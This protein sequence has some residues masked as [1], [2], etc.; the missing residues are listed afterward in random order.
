MVSRRL[1]LGA[2]IFCLLVGV[3]GLGLYV[4]QRIGQCGYVPLL[5]AEL[6]PNADLATP[7]AVPRMPQGWSAAAA[8]VEL[9]AFAVDG[10][11]RSLQLMGIANYVQT[12]PI[13]VTG[14]QVYCF[15][16][17]AL[18]D[19]VQ[20]SPTR[21]QLTFHWLA[22]DGTALG[23]AAGPW[24]PVALWQPEAPPERWSTIS[25]AARAPQD[26]VTLLV[27]IHPASDDRVYLDA[28]HVRRGGG[29]LLAG[30]ATLAAPVADASAAEPAAPLLAPWPY[31]QRAA[32]AFTFDWETTMGGLIHS[33]SVGDPNF[34]AD[35]VLR[36]LRMREG[37][38]NTLAIFRPYDL[39]ATYYATG[40]NFLT[41]NTARERF[42]GDPIYEWANPANGWLSE[43][44]QTTPWFADDPYGT[45]RSH[46]AWYFGDLIPLLQ[47]AGQDIQ[48]HTFSH[49]H[50]GLVASQEW[51]ADLQAWNRVA[52]AQN[53]PSA[54]SLAFPWS[55]SAGMSDASWNVLDAAG[56]RSVT[57]LSDQ[58]Q[59]NLFPRDEAGLVVAP[60][61]RP[62]PGHPRILA[63]PDFYLTP[64]SADLAIR[65]I[66]HTLASG[67]MIDLWAHTEEVTTPAQ[68]AAWQRVVAYAVDQPDLWVAPLTEIADWQ[69]ALAQVAVSAGQ[70]AD[71]GGLMFRV[72]NDSPRDLGGLTLRMPFVVEQVT[73]NGDRPSPSY[74]ALGSQLLTLDL[75]A[76][77]SLE[78]VAWP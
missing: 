62:L 3:F 20:R 46:P 6:L 12:P 48:S 69:Q 75:A 41:G 14:G 22:A 64:A 1:L 7:G 67:G 21:L 63:C 40:Y 68:I 29:G 13:D 71:A 52:A 39:R 38:T 58:A 56:I 35:P 11:G 66:D 57:R 16:G 59:Y 25:A 44:W 37:I 78:V 5:A 74:P 27:R 61:C 60:H 65:Q 54:R 36:G 42:M 26:A 24:Q 76:G 2:T 23:V 45:Y 15:R 10:D 17:L 31:G 30:E 49:F 8:G 70:P 77:Q 18:T 19:S 43:R 32:L 47:A 73:L 50:G 53:V 4:Q 9:G 72:A 55:S 51:I 28:M 33:R 34:D